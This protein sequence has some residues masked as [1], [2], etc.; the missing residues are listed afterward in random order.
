M[1]IVISVI[2]LIAAITLLA[3]LM[4]KTG[5]TAMAYVVGFGLVIVLAWF[6]GNVITHIETNQESFSIKSLFSKLDD[7][8]K[9]LKAEFERGKASVAPT[10]TSS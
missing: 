5:V 8:I 4:F 10:K 9:E 1:K 7:K 2:S 6:S 3:W